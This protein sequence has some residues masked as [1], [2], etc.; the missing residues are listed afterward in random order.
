VLV[1]QRYACA[2]LDE[3]APKTYAEDLVVSRLDRGVTTLHSGG[4][5]GCN[6]L[7]VRLAR[8]HSSAVVVGIP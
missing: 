7:H 2:P 4:R 8:A 5:A 6:S 3:P 1:T